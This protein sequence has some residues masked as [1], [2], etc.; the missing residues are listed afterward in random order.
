MRKEATTST[1][2]GSVR[3]GKVG[4]GKKNSHAILI[5]GKI[6]RRQTMG[7]NY[8]TARVGVKEEGG[9]EGTVSRVTYCNDAEREPRSIKGKTSIW[10]GKPRG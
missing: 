9:T 8:P 3:G 4:G 7:E 10:K 6:N 2:S 1:K 5:K